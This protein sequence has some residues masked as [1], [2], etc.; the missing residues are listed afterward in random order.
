MIAAANDLI[1]IHELRLSA[2]ESFLPASLM[3]LLLGVAAVS[4]YLLAWSFG[5]AGHGGRAAMLLLALLV[6]LLLQQ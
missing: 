6:D 2:V 4:I 1:D 3:M 5:A